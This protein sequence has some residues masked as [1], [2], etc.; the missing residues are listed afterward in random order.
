MRTNKIKVGQVTLNLGTILNSRSYRINNVY[1]L[2]KCYDQAAKLKVSVDFTRI[3]EAAIQ[4]AEGIA[5]NEYQRI[6]QSMMYKNSKMRERMID[7]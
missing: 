4:G 6:R 5:S 2:E 3:E 1:N 7:D